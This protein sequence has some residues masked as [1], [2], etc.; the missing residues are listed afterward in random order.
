MLR[1]QRAAIA[2]AVGSMAMALAACGGSSSSTSASSAA[3]SEAPVAASSAAASGDG[4]AVTYTYNSDAEGI[5]SI[6]GSELNAEFGE[7]TPSKKYSIGVVLKALT[8][9]YWQ[10]I[11]AGVKQAAAD[12][13]ADVV[14]QAATS[15]SDQNEQLSITQTLVAQGFDAYVVAP[16]STSNLTPALD[17]MKAANAPIV[18]VDDARVPAT[19]YVGPPHQDDGTQAAETFAGLFPDGGQVAQIEGQAGSSAAILRIKGFKE[20]V[21]AAGNLELVASVPA[22]WDANKAFAAT[23]Q[24]IQQYPDLKGIYANNDTMAIGVAKAVE[25]SGKDIKVIGT[26][27]VPEAVDAVRKGTMYATVSPLPFYQGY[28]SV[29]S[30]IR[31]L[32]GQAIPPWVKAPAQL[33][34]QENVDQFYNDKGMVLPGLF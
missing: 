20:G 26:D 2:L 27:G 9:Q 16:Q 22:D 17:Q 10:G 14:V 15:E 12:Y 25:E 30:A 6:P 1:I 7:L 13:G 18:N 4:G 21:D 3:A 5:E 29:E 23:Q 19:V 32:E 8:N 34:T 28:W 31:L 24:L 33:I 11:E